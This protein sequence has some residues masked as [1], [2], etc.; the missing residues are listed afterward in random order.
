MKTGTKPNAKATVI[1]WALIAWAVLT[2]VGHISHPLL[3]EPLRA[4]VGA[5]VRVSEL[6]LAILILG[7]LVVFKFWIKPRLSPEAAQRVREAGER[8]RNRSSTPGLRVTAILLATGVAVGALLKYSGAGYH[9][10][11]H[12]SRGSV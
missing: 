3:S 12:R 6:V 11:R 8:E 7:G 10:V 9:A 1:A 5:A 4:Q 2:W